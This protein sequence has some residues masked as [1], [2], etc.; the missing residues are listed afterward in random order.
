M[1]SDI[2]KAFCDYTEICLEAH[3]NFQNGFD[4]ARTAFNEADE[5]EEPFDIA[6]HAFE[7]GYKHL[8]AKLKVAVEALDKIAKEYYGRPATMMIEAREA[9]IQIKA[10]Q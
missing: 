4:D 2:E 3:E 5:D 9:L 10:K 8:E 7:A 6:E 1:Q